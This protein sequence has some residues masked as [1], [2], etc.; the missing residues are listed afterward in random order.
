MVP[1]TV[2]TKK[3]KTK[4]NFTQV[5]TDTVIKSNNLNKKLKCDFEEVDHLNKMDMK[6]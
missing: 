3:T 1:T 2:F 6:I 4:H 5:H